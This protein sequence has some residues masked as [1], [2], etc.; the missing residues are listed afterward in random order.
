M[1]GAAVGRQ[2]RLFYEFELEDMV[3]ADHF[4]RK[5]DAVLDLSWLRAELAPYYSHLGCPSVC[6]ELMVR[7]LL[8][9]Y[10]YSIRSG[11]RP[12]RSS[13]R[14]IMVSVARTSLVMRVGVASTS[15]ITPSSI[16]IR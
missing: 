16:S 2:D 6:P 1:M 12:K 7:M 10:C 15:S 11:L 4:L 14:S 13:M 9:G 3:P 8:V 5:I